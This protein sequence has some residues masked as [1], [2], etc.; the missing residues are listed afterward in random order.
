MAVMRTRCNDRDPVDIR[1]AWNE[2]E[3]R[4]AA[5]LASKISRP[6]RETLETV[7]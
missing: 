2:I 4:A 6:R 1:V 5:K 3:L 7:L